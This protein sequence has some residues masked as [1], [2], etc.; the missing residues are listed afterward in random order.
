MSAN[1]R[2]IIRTLSID[3][4][5]ADQRCGMDLH[6]HLGAVVEAALANEL[7]FLFDAAGE[8]RLE[9]LDLDLGVLPEKDWEP[10][11]R[12]NLRRQLA[13]ALRP[14]KAQDAGFDK[15]AA[16][17]TTNPPQSGARDSDTLQAWLHFLRVGR[18]PWWAEH[19][20]L[21]EIEAALLD[22]NPL[23]T[24]ETAE[25]LRAFFQTH[26]E[27]I[28]RLARQ[29]TRALL[30]KLWA[31][32]KRPD[33]PEAA[34][35]DHRTDAVRQLADLLRPLVGPAHTETLL[36]EVFF[37]ESAL[38]QTA[39]R[40]PARITFVLRQRL[41]QRANRDASVEAQ[42]AQWVKAGAERLKHKA[43]TSTRKG[44]SP[45]KQK[46]TGDS[47]AESR[48]SRE[49]A[50]DNNNTA[51][52]GTDFPGAR[53]GSQQSAKP[54]RP[55]EPLAE[56][57]SFY[58]EHA[59][60]VLL[61]PFLPA[62][63]DNRQLLQGGLF[64]NGEAQEKAVQWLHFLACGQTD[65]PEPE[66]ALPKILCGMALETPV[67]RLFEPDAEGLAE[68]DS[69]LSAVVQHWSVLKNTSPEGLREGFLR[70][71]GKLEAQTENAWKLTVERQS[72]D[73]LLEQLPWGFG[74][75][76]LP[77]MPGLLHVEW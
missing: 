73:L 66:L 57:A 62:F 63:F 41:L 15:P 75:I 76:R 31:A 68:A 29:S 60:L 35:S 2:H 17:N 50:A 72:I 25:K 14:A 22:E 28:A 27:A 71:S 77:W 45:D 33:A 67:A 12:E 26:P 51:K 10:A 34:F 18:L 1:N 5:C 6:A 70:R 30:A 74:I 59:G 47:K 46:T 56:N 23:Q 11:L 3:A 21:T 32:L 40:W 36:A 61:H 43:D 19:R 38:P 37:E 55:S 4:S 7:Q 24:P 13:E 42:L 39:G 52:S 16:G 49:S 8:V 54:Q 64:T 48:Q 69:L 20:R 53:R 65:C 9:R 44:E 58:L